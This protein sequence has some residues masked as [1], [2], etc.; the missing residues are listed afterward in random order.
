LLIDDR[1]TP[2]D[3]GLVAARQNGHNPPGGRAAGA[4][5]SQQS[6]TPAA[7]SFTAASTP[8]KG[9]FGWHQSPN[10]ETVPGSLMEMSGSS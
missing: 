3:Q 9:V 8:L 2:D 6:R 5:R 7:P 1:P 10:A 4:Y